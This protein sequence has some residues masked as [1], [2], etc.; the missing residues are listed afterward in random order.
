MVSE[1]SLDCN[2]KNNLSVCKG[3]EGLSGRKES[4]KNGRREN[5]YN[6]N[7]TLFPDLNLER[8]KTLDVS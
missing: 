8:E 3:S 2:M 5:S 4:D 7:P 6:E 1:K